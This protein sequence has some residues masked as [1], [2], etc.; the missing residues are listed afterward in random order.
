MLQ[1]WDEA[2]VLAIAFAEEC[3]PK[4]RAG[5]GAAGKDS[6]RDRI[7][8]IRTSRNGQ[9]RRLSICF[10]SELPRALCF[11]DYDLSGGLCS[12]MS[13]G[14]LRNFYYSF[15]L[16][17]ERAKANAVQGVFPLSFFEGFKAPSRF[18]EKHRHA[19]PTDETVGL[20]A[21][22]AQGDGGASDYAEEAHIQQGLSVGALHLKKMM[23]YRKPAPRSAHKQGCMMDDTTQILDVPLDLVKVFL[24]TGALQKKDVDLVSIN[25]MVKSYA[26]NNLISHEGKRIRRA[27]A[28]TGWGA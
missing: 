22:L 6:I 10:T 16:T 21:T 26:E 19:K 11:T 17:E 27:A 5:L 3:P 23:A 1:L 14:G 8:L 9:E 25:R 28:H 13:A 2:D 18:T 20:L 24:G 4:L 12:L 15:A 7:I